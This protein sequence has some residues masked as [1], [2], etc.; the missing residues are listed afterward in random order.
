MIIYKTAQEIEKIREA[1]QII[2]TLLDKILPEKIRPGIST[3]DLDKIAEDYILS[4]GARPGFKGYRVGHLA[5]PNTL[6]ISINDEVIHGIPSK[7]RILVEGDIVSID[8]GTIID[9]YYGDAART[10]PVGKITKKD[11]DL[12]QVTKKALKIGIENARVGNRISDI[13]HAIQTY[14][15]KEGYSV[16]RDYCGHGVGKA[17]HEDPQVPNFGKKGRGSRIENGMV[18]AIEP[19]VNIGSYEVKTQKDGWTAVTKDGKRSA[20]FE[21]SVAI[22]DGQAVILSAKIN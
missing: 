10:Y 7:K 13:G 11:E 18:L 4:Q 1:N 16:V 19:M 17:L 6:C 9:G 21:N 3:F 8:V 22:V 14:V 2:A 5:F 15:E 12:L 20:H